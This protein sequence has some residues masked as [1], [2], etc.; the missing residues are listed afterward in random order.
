MGV[1]VGLGTDG[2]VSN[3]S[4]DM[5][6]VM[7]TTALLHKVHNLRSDLMDALQVLEMATIG[8]AK[9]LG[10][11]HVTGSL[12]AG[13]RADILLLN[14]HCPRMIPCYSMVSNLVY[15]ASS[16]V[17]DTVIIE[18]RIVAENGRCVSLDRR[19]VMREARRLERYLLEKLR[20]HRPT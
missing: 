4:L 6:E 18:G 8:G 10:I 2:A 7:K 5:F 9:A 12:E 20:E 14:L 16:T 19:E 17:V 1:K 13:K 11:D 15:S 3:N